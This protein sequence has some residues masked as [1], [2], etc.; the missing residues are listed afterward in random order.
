MPN[1]RVREDNSILKGLKLNLQCTF[2]L[3][4]LVICP[5]LNDV[6]VGGIF[7]HGVVPGDDLEADRLGEGGEGGGDVAS[8]GG[9]LV[10]AGE[11]DDEL[12]GHGRGRVALDEAGNG[13]I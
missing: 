12:A 1:P 13:L 10:E 5:E 8:A 3:P 11:L 7:G 2:F 9:L 4:H 6:K